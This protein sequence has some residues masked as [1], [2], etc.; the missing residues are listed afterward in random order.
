VALPTRH[1]LK[2][3]KEFDLV[4]K[5]GKLVRDKLF[6]ILFIKDETSDGPKFGLVVSKKI[7]KRAVERNRIRRLLAEA[8]AELLAETDKSLK[9]V[10]LA[11]HPLKTATLPEIKEVFNRMRIL[12]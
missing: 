9:F 1:R 5:E 2:K 3:K 12:W 10:I 8:I 6:S 7:D 4:K 11:K